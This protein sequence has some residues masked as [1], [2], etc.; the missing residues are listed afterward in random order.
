MDLPLKS[1]SGGELQR[2]AVVVCLG[3]PAQIFLLDEPS[4]ALDCEQ[5]VAV[6]KV[7][8]RWVVNHCGNTAF[9]VEHDFA[10]AA[11]LADRVVVFSGQPG[12]SCVAGA[13]Q[14]VESGFNQLLQQLNASMRLDPDN[15][16]PVVNKRNSAL[17]RELKSA[18][19]Y[20]HFDMDPDV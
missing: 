11:I 14:L 3:T 13:P 20:Y 6:A 17:D 4:A 16:R 5:R 12:V 10:M 19:K 8:K 9:V 7:I 2:L 15:G 1:L 18:G